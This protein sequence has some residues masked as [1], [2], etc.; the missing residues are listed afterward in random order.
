MESG[1]GE[2]GSK[3]EQLYNNAYCQNYMGLWTAIYIVG[4]G[5]EMGLSDPESRDSKSLFQWFCWSEKKITKFISHVLRGN[6]GY[7]QKGLCIL[8][9]GQKRNKKIAY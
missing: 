8:K 5:V 7:I 3:C 4:R 1:A 9:L 6:F 2:F